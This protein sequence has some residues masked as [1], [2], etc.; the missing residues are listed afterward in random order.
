MDKIRLSKDHKEK[1]AEYGLGNVSPDSC[2]GFR[3]SSGEVFKL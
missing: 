2:R 3:F 1:L